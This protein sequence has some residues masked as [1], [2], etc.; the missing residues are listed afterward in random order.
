MCF[1]SVETKKLAFSKHT[2]VWL[3]WGDSGGVGSQFGPPLGLW[4]PEII[5]FIQVKELKIHK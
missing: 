3:N 5:L 4:R 2:S 1:C